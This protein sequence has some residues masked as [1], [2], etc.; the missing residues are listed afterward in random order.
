VSR[1]YVGSVSLIKDRY[2]RD[3]AFYQGDVSSA[4]SGCTDYEKPFLYLFFGKERAMLE[5]S[6]SGP[7]ETAPYVDYPD[8]QDPLRYEFETKSG[9][10]V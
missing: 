6:G 3:T 7:A 1:T 5:D 4:E 2:D 10:S 9:P 8:L